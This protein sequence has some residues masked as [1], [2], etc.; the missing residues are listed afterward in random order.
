MRLVP[1][2]T[3]ITTRY[4]ALIALCLLSC[5]DAPL[6][7]QPSTVV[8]QE[9]ALWGAL[10]PGAYGVGF[11]SVFAFDKSRTWQSTRTYSGQFSADLNYRPVQVNLWYPAAPDRGRAAMTYGDYVEQTAPP[12][13]STLNDLML[14]RNREGARGSFDKAS[15][16]IL[17]STPMAAVKTSA[18]AKGRFPLVFVIGG[19][20]AEINTNVVLAEYLASH[21]YAVASISLTGQ[22]ADQP[23]QSRAPGDLEATVR[24]LEFATSVICE[25]NNIDCSRIAAIGHS[26]GAIEAVLLAQRHGNV[27]AAVGLDGTYGFKGNESV[28]TKAYGYQPDSFRPALFDLRRAQGEQSADINLE[29]VLALAH[30]ERTLV[31][32]K[33]MHHSD[34]TSFAMSAEKFAVPIKA[35]YNGTGWDRATA[36]KGYE[37]SARLVLAFLDDEVKQVAHGAEHF[38]ASIQAAQ[39]ATFRHIDAA[40]S[41]PSPAEFASLLASKSTDEI[42]AIVQTSCANVPLTACV[43]AGRFNN[44]AY[45]LLHQERTDQAIALFEFVAWSHPA[46]ANAQDS[47]ADAYLSKGDRGKAKSAVERALAL[48]PH[49]TSLDEAARAQIV[50]DET[51]RL[52]EW[53]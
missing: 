8:K 6:M 41:I 15:L 20:N 48:A 42:R 10:E 51:R 34:F 45:G 36:R 5:V 1:R 9:H 7:A 35:S 43:D 23:E 25:A 46:S 2:S 37:T 14:A 50:A 16:P 32:L 39:P 27:V 19:L 4:V 13:F 24:D 31:S 38:L 11:R 3:S 26:L 52:N 28:L 22:T 47:L 12:A 18:P 21:G 29:P 30:A 17:L 53:R 44:F 33:G 49:D 40:P